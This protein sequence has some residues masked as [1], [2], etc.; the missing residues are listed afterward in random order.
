MNRRVN[1][2]IYIYIYIYIYK[3]DILKVAPGEAKLPDIQLIIY[4]KEKLVNWQMPEVN[5]S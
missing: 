1:G 3:C 2:Y 5:H 4:G